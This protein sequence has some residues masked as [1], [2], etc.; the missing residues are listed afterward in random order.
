MNRIFTLFITAS[1]AALSASAQQKDY[2]KGVFIVNEDWFGHNS[3]SVNFL[4][5]DGTWDYNVVKENNPGQSLGNTAEYGAIHNGRMYIMSKQ[6][7]SDDQTTGG[8]ITVCDA[9]TMKIEASIKELKTDGDKASADARS[10]CAVS[11]TKAY[12]SSTNGIY[13]LDLTTNAITGKVEGI[14]DESDGLYN[15]QTGTMVL[16]GDKVYAVH[17]SLG[18]LIID[19]ASDKVVGTVKHDDYVYG[20]VVKSKDGMLWLSTTLADGTAQPFIVRLDPATGKTKNIDIPKDIYAPA[21]SWFAWT[22]DCFCASAKENCL[23]WNGGESSWTSNQS[24]FKYDID[25]NSFSQIINLA[26]DDPNYY[27]YGASCRVHPQT[28][29]LYIGMTIGAWSNKTVERIY[30]NTGKKLNEYQLKEN[31]WFPSIPVFPESGPSDGIETGTA[32]TAT[33]TLTA[34][35]TIDG[36]RISSPQRGI[37]I[38][39]YSDGTTKKVIVK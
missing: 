1:L 10:F 3:S 32:A 12:V 38:L 6:D 14:K 27:I 39:H 11:D 37:N 15:T 36:K 9:K 18:L 13:I 8:R 30:D 22:P 5:E 20:S 25:A 2:T 7:Y 34:R 28:D 17:Q 31:Y 19:T 33:R 21:N 16:S 4:N 35:Y 29:Q 23:Y 26:K 24:I